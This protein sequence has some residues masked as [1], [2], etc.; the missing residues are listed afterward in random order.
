[1]VVK[2]SKSFEN[3]GGGGLLSQSDAD[4]DNIILFARANQMPL[5][6]P[7]PIKNLTGGPNF[8]PTLVFSRLLTSHV[9]LLGPTM[10][11]CNLWTVESH[12]SGFW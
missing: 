9:K 4:I 6:P 11:A 10:R 5:N 1:M 8:S 7:G 12:I 3:V 2:F